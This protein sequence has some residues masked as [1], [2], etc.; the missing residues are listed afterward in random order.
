MI[1]R[2]GGSA[3]LRIIVMDGPHQGEAHGGGRCGRDLAGAVGIKLGLDATGQGKPLK[4]S[5]RA[6]ASAPD[7]ELISWSAGGDRRA[8][9]QIVSR[10]GPFALRIALRL[11]A[12]PLAA[13]DIVQE[14]MLRAWSQAGHF[15]P[16]RARFTTWLYR[17][18][19]NL[20]IDQRRRIL[21]ESMPDNFDPVDLSAGADD[22]L[23]RA[24]RHESLA[25]ALRE[26]P[27]RQ[28]AALTLVYDEGMT[29]AEAAQILGVTVKALERLLARGRAF[30]RQHIGPEH[31]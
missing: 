21:P 7:A 13:E 24:E 20:S 15:D 19:L 17:I 14:A 16:R 28:R 9:D 22:I 6:Y 5:E 23:E 31:N 26:L 27:G 1:R 25:R 8:F 29:G 18:V 11:I 4:M 3:C 30:L 12:D 2:P 10:H